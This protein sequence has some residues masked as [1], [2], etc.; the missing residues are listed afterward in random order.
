MI[1]KLPESEASTI[2][3][4][5]SGKINA[6]EEN[7]W[8]AI[9]DALLEENDKINILVV[10]DGK[11]NIGVDVVY[12]DLKWAFKNIKRMNKLAIVSDSRVLSWLVALDSPFGKLVGI[13]EKHFESNQ[14]Q[15]AWAWV[16]S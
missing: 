13:S 6:E 1:R 7:Q 15:E 5:V 8:I 11:I 16:K 14:L 4:E 12:A 9:F 2:G 10:L 3:V